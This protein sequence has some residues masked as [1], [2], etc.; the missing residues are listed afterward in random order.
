M[1]QPVGEKKI[2]CNGPYCDQRRIH[3]EMQHVMRPRQMV[4]VPV[5]Y[6][7]EAYCSITCAVQDGAMDINQPPEMTPKEREELDERLKVI[8]EKLK[9]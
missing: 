5:D 3:Y 9:K 8:F 7:G 4:S 1:S 2:P 6:E